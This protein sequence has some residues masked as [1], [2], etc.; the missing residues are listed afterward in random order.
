MNKEINI[1]KEKEAETG[2]RI[3]ASNDKFLDKFVHRDAFLP[4]AEEVAREI[5]KDVIE[6]GDK[7]VVDAIQKYEGVKLKP[8]DLAVELGN[9]REMEQGLARDI[10]EA[11]KLA[12]GRIKSFAEDSMKKP[13]NKTTL[14]G[15]R[16]GEFYTPI[17]RVGVYVPG[18]TAPL[19][20]TALH[21][22]TLAKVAG[23]KQIV[24][25]TPAGKDGKVNEILLY[26]MRCAGVNEVYKVGG[27]QAI[28]MMA[29]G[30]KT[31]PK[32][33][34]IVG[35]GNAFV[36]AAKRAVYGLVS[37]DQ[38]AGPS[39]IA[40]VADAAAKP[41]WIAADMLSQAEHG[42]GH[43]KALLITT[44]PAL[45]EAVREEITVQAALLSRHEMVRR[46]IKN[47]GILIVLAKD[48]Q[49]AMAVA[50]DFAPEHLE[51]MTKDAITLMK[52]VKKAGAIFAG[53]WTPE[54]VGDFVAG[55]SHVLPTG[56]SAAM[57]NGLTTD[58]FRRRHSFVA[59]SKSDLAETRSAIET[60][61][62]L[63]GLGAHGRSA[64]IRFEA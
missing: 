36:T 8:S 48:L 35:P 26:A 59:F 10:V 18:G 49:E 16:V 37:L 40:I 53:P 17:E 30:T 5:I 33:E 24:A 57:F 29:V 63:E 25:C 61:A 58:D 39:E 4:E 27:A 60:L 44:S 55:P 34:K 19:I 62:Q 32:V 3:V 45:A 64:T 51:I 14:R 7:A 52:S 20:S 12:L 56:G 42:S 11:I 6:R 31:C 15:G 23:V 38:V 28:T 1:G 54:C 2:I 50:N 13:W 47:D 21:T 43:E 9:I 22:A 46:V 41:R